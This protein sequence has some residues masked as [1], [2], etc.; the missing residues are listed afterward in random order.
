MKCD[1]GDGS[2]LSVSGHTTLIRMFAGGVVSRTHFLSMGGADEDPALFSQTTQIMNSRVIRLSTV[3]NLTRTT[4][5][6]A[7][8]F[9]WYVPFL[10]NT[11]PNLRVLLVGIF[12]ARS[13]LESHLDEARCVQFAVQATARR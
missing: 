10:W 13:Y 3:M 6:P 5:F 1:V 12:N 11:M 2:C 8:V 7:V 4:N 9:S